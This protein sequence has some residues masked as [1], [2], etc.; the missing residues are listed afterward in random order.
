MQEKHKVMGEAVKDPR[1]AWERCMDGIC[2]RWLLWEA[3]GKGRG[4]SGLWSRAAGRARQR[5]ARAK[6]QA[7]GDGWGTERSWGGRR[8]GFGHSPAGKGSACET[9]RSK[10]AQG[11]AF[12]RLRRREG[13]CRA[14][15][16]K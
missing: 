2:R 14:F 8:A 6:I 1:P 11:T 5:A 9:E 15:L 13:K 4:G 3:A 16:L 10:G 7:G 12:V